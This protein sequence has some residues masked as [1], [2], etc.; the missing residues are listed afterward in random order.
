MT[1]PL[2]IIVEGP[3]RSGKG[4]FVNRLRERLVTPKL[5]YMHLTKPPKLLDIKKTDNPSLLFKEWAHRRLKHQADVCGTLLTFNDVVIIDRA[6]FSEFVY[7]PLYRDTHYDGTDF[8]VAEGIFLSTINKLKEDYTTALVYF[9][10]TAEN[11][12]ERDDGESHSTD[13]NDKKLEIQF[14]DKVINRS[15]IE[16]KFITNWNEVEFSIDAID[17]VIDKILT[18]HV[19][20]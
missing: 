1:K 19:G 7:G 8:L 5:V 20:T 4:T 14:Y 9:S 3:D 12:I 16:N 13:I 18:V 10:D 6:Y 11:F 15:T 2:F 17:K